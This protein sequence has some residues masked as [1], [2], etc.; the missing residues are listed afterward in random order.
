MPKGVPNPAAMYGIY[1]RSWG[2]EVSIVRSGVRYFQQFGKASY[3]GAEHAL[4][5]A[6]EWRDAVVKSVPPVTRRERAEKL[7]AS[8]T[9]GVPGVFCLASPD[10]KGLSWLAKTYIAAEEI[11]RANFP[12]HSWGDA[13]RKL[14]IEER[15]RQLDRMTGLAALHPAEEAI[16][17]ASVAAPADPGPPKRSRSEIIRK[18]NSSG[19]SGV[20]FK[21][22]RPDHPGYW[23]AITYTAGKG[24]VSKAF[25]VKA[26]G[27]DEAKSLAA[28]ERTRQL[29]QKGIG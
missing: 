17:K 24:S 20:H 16:R 22:P 23:L 5:R 13:A 19:M 25:S 6:Q 28:A 26:H 1:A 8:N 4:R 12:I 18:S 21:R 15:A 9:T 2:F 7:R 10:G 3:G 11:L 29:Y 14:A 27:Y